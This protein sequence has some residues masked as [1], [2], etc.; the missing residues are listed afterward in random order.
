MATMPVTGVVDNEVVITLEPVKDF[1]CRE[2]MVHRDRGNPDSERVGTRL[3]VL[4]TKLGRAGY[5]ASELLFSCLCVTCDPDKKNRVLRA[6]LVIPCTR[7]DTI[8]A[9]RELLRI[10]RPPD[11]RGRR[12]D[13]KTGLLIVKKKK[14]GPPT[15]QELASPKFLNAVR[16]VE[17][18]P[19]DGEAPAY[20]RFVVSQAYTWVPDKGARAG[21]TVWEQSTIAADS[22]QRLITTYLRPPLMEDI[23]W[24]VRNGLAQELAQALLSH[25]G[26][27]KEGSQGEVGEASMSH[28]DP[29]EVRRLRL[30]PE[31]DE[32]GRVDTATHNFK[33]Q[34]LRFVNSDDV[35]LYQR[36]WQEHGRNRTGLYAA[37]PLPNVVEAKHQ[38]RVWWRTRLAEFTALPLW[39]EAELSSKSKVLVLPVA[40]R[41][42]ST[43]AAILNDYTTWKPC[44]S[45]VV[46]REK[47]FFLQII[48]SRRVTPIRRPNVLGVHFAQVPVDNGHQTVI[49]WSLFGLADNEITKQG[50]VVVDLLPI[51]RPWPSRAERKR[52]SYEAARRVVQLALEHNADLAVEEVSGVKKRGSD[53][54]ANA[55]AAR[56]NYSDLATR[57]GHKAC[58]VP[59]P[60]AVW[61][62]SSWWLKDHGDKPYSEQA[63]MVARGG[64]AVRNKKKK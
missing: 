51:H 53:T 5:Q 30:V 37:I 35:V 61:P 39:P 56:F 1:R 33:R 55:L 46:P 29:R 19:E 28:S 41:P 25:L 32:A 14:E 15:P 34:P 60:V 64:V 7:A 45:L 58:D 49:Y 38:A 24:V 59:K 17:V 21:Q 43:A 18:S 16:L 13:K 10:D 54:E 4:S 6:E 9:A 62:V 31:V 3:R 27:K 23:P 36:H 26:L 63:D 44:W 20:L 11:P 57:I 2:G 42:D 8:A 48:I 50:E 12:Y 52:L 40:L 22:L 47:E